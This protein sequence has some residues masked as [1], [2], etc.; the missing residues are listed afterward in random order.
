MGIAGTAGWISALVGGPAELV[1][2]MQQRTGRG[3]MDTVKSVVDM[4]GAGMLKRGMMMTACRD[5][6]W[7]ASY[8]ALGP[9]A[10]MQLHEAL[11]NVFGPQ[12][13]ASLQQRALAAVGGSAA[14]GLVTVMVTQPLDTVKTVMQGQLADGNKNSLQS[15]RQTTAALIK[16]GGVKALYK[17]TLARGGRLVGGIM[18]LGQAKVIFEDLFKVYIA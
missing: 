11:P 15:L 13:T 6:V 4:H 16:Q 2:T 1:M 14:A 7:S 3:F 9:M 10:S 17:G 5:S 8:L 18:I 12:D